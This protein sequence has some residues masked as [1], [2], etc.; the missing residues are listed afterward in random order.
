MKKNLQKKNKEQLIE[1]CI[2]C[3]ELLEYLS[4]K[5]KFGKIQE[6]KQYIDDIFK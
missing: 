3:Y 2:N 1:I 5:T 4:N 6:L